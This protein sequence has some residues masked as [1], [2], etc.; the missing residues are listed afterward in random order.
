M[1]HVI[2]E[3]QPEA[4]YKSCK[5]DDFKFETTADLVTTVEILG[6]AR[7]ADAVRFGLGI[8]RDGYNIFA[9]GPAGTGKQFLT[10]HFPRDRASKRSI[11]PDLC[12]VTAQSR[13][14]SCLQDEIG[15]SPL[16]SGEL[17]SRRICPKE[18]RMR[19]RML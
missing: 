15:R 11:P 14:S 3:L 1:A 13:F 6:Q 2:A 8:E 17:S 7:A 18:R 10:E 4:H 19:S 5:P 9:L 12:Y 16:V